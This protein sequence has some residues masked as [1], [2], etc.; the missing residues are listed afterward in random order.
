[1]A[2]EVAPINAD[3]EY[4]DFLEDPEYQRF[5][6]WAA[7]KCHCANGPCDGVLAGGFC[8]GFNHER[9]EDEWTDYDYG[10][11]CDDE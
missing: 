10:D 5:L 9:D 3:P 4:Q 2:S 1:M 8:D 7:S 11:E 6:N